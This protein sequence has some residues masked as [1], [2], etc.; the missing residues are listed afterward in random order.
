KGGGGGRTGK[1]GG[2]KG[3]SSAMESQDYV[4][5]MKSVGKQLPGGRELFGNASLSFTHGAKIGV[6]GVNGSGKSTVLKILAGQDKE[7]DG[8]V[9][10]KEG[11]RVKYLSQEP[12]LDLNLNVMDN[13]RIGIAEQ[14]SLVRRFEEVSV[15]MGDPEADLDALLAEQSELQSR[16]DEADAWTLQHRVD[17]SMRKLRVPP[18]DSPVAQLSGGE[19]RRV[20]L[21]RLL[22]EMPDIVLL[23]EPT[24]HLDAESVLWL[25]EYLRSF[26]GT[27]ISIT[28]D[29]YFLDNVAS[30][31]LEV[32][33]GVLI[34]YK[35][36]YSEWLHQKQGR[37]DLEHTKQVSV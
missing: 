21:C 23:D 3:G 36:N 6:L 10:I 1:G 24:N 31:I 30:W 9:W 35:G 33:R 4:M 14:E 12:D 28:H 19:K 7:H 11:L 8:E 26:K 2:A 15:S 22:L 32:D 13:I 29:R 27:V 25:E 20:A 37:L 17:I 34:P 18:G 16:I 5:S